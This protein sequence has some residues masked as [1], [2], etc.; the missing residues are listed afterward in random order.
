LPDGRELVLL[1]LIGPV[2]QLSV[3]YAR[4][5]FYAD[6][7]HYDRLAWAWDALCRW[8]GTGEPERWF[9]HPATGRRRPGGDP[10]AEYVQP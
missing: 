5:G 1:P 2:T 8:D 9:R 4:D 6:T 10:V 3:S 7:W